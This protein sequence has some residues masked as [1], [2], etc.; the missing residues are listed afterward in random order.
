[1][2]YT[3]QPGDSLWSIARRVCNDGLRWRDIAR[4]NP[5]IDPERL[6][7]GQVLHIDSALV[8]AQPGM[9]AMG[10][11]AGFSA[12]PRGGGAIQTQ[13]PTVAAQQP[14]LVPGAYYVFVLADEIDPTRGKV[15]RRVLV[16]PRMAAE[17]ARQAGRPLQLF[18]HPERFGFQPT[19]PGSPLSLGRH[20][21]GMKPSPYSSAST[22]LLGARRFVGTPFWIDVPAAQA[23]G[24]TLHETAE[25]LADL[26][27]IAAKAVTDA[28]K[29]RIARIRALVAADQ[30]VLIKGSVPAGAVKG[31]AAMAMTRGLQGVQIIGFA[32][33]AVN[34][35]HATEKSVRTQSARPIAAETVRQVGG[36]AAAWAG[37]K[38][39]AAGGALVGI[40]TGPGALLTGA[41]GGV[42]GGVAGYFG[43]DWIADHI[44]EN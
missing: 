40:E 16:N 34:M 42:V 31:P 6:L 21:L 43:F 5:Q 10:E 32:M 4:S 36:W 2:Q 25:I 1:M 14:A 35:A 28:D 23:A 8:P 7:V 29:A 13:A 33:T 12:P 18:P 11:T 41:A 15:V 30:E 22:G 38:L 19:G 27:R 3:V 39:G 44:D 9:A 20:A 37:M 17:A 24:A 26:D